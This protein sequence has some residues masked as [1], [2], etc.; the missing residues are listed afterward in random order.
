M[1]CP[2][3]IESSYSQHLLFTLKP[4]SSSTPSHERP[5]FTCIKQYPCSRMEVF[6]GSSSFMNAISNWGIITIFVTILMCFLHSWMVMSTVPHSVP[7]AGVRREM[8]SKTRACV[9]EFT[10]GL[11]TLKAGYEQVCETSKYAKSD[12]S[13][14]SLIGKPYHS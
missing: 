4:S 9:R 5:T 13:F 7:W 10:A 3:L 8:F 1:H 14:C 2:L 11:Q 12:R 6:S